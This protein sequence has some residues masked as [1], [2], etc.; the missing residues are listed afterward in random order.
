MKRLGASPRFPGVSP[1]VLAKE[2]IVLLHRI[3]YR[4]LTGNRGRFTFCPGQS[5]PATGGLPNGLHESGKDENDV[6]MFPDEIGIYVHIP[7]CRRLCSFC[8]YTKMLYSP[9][10]AGTYLDCLRVEAAMLL[11]QMNGSKVSS[12]YFGGGTPLTL[13]GAIESMIDL[14]SPHLVSGAGIA[15][16]VHPMDAKPKIMNWLRQA[17]VT[18]AS[19]GIE[20]LDQGVLDILGR[21]YDSEAAHAA[22]ETVM[23][24]GFKTVNVDLMTCIPGQSLEQTTDD[25]ECLLEY[26]VGQ[27]SAYPLM[28]FSFTSP[29][30]S[31]PPWDQLRVLSALSAAG[32]AR[33]YKRSSVWT[34]TK[35]HTDKYTSITRER[36]AG[37]GAGAAT[38]L[39]GYFGLNTFHVSAYI[40]CILSGKPPVALY[41]AL[42]PEESALYWLFWRCYEGEVDLNSPEINR[43]KNFS[44]LSRLAGR[45]GLVETAPSATAAPATATTRPAMRLTERGLLLYHFLERYYTRLY[46]GRLWQAC[47]DSD[48]PQE[49]VL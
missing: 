25:F 10:I 15:V 22:I 46:I 9:G 26:G 49:T 7:F 34:W 3:L 45:L 8:P 19:L 39:D 29:V 37:V 43:L 23:G 33:G 18:M 21:G 20:S 28:D 5:G 38:Y 42:T 4:A 16:E 32:H 44:R 6:I 48:F 40:D 14:M 36:F 47:R 13:P 1:G 17:G 30:S 12:V 35:P 11:K 41:S 27:V 24:T 31:Y 2:V